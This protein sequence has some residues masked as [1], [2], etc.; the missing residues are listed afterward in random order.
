MFPHRFAHL[1]EEEFDMNNF[2]LPSDRVNFEDDQADPSIPDRLENFARKW[3]HRIAL[4]T[5]KISLPWDNLNRA[6]N[7]IGRAV[8][9]IS[10]SPWQQPIGLL[11]D[12]ED[13]LVATLG[14][15][16]A[17]GICVAL[18][19]AYP[20]ARLAY[21]LNDTESTLILTNHRY[22]P[23]GLE[24]AQGKCSVINIDALDSCLSTEN[25]G[26]R[27]PSASTCSIT[28]T[29]GSTGEPKGIVNTHR[30]MIQSLVY[31]EH[32]KLGPDDHFTDM[33]SGERNPFSA[34]LNG[35]SL[36]PWYIKEDGL[37]SLSDWLI[38]EE[39]TAFRAG[40][41]VF[42]QFVSNLSGKEEFPQ[43]R[44]IILAGEPM[45]KADVELY[46]RHF[47]ASCVLVNL[48]GAHEVG[49]F[50]IFV[51]N[52]NTEIAGDRVPAGYEIAGKKVLLFDEDRHELGADEV[53]EIAVQSRSLSL[54][55]WRKPALSAAKFLAA[56]GNDEGRIYLTGDLGRMLPNGCLE[57]LGRK[58][59]RVKIRGFS[60][61]IA[62]VEKALLKHAGI[63]EATVTARQDASGEAQLV[64]YFVPSGHAASTVTSLRK[65]L[66][67]SL[68]DY[69]I[70]SVF[71]KLGELPTIGTGT[72]KLD[73]HALPEPGNQRPDLDSSFVA[74]ATPVEKILAE[75]WAEALSMTEI[76]VDDNFFDLGGHSLT[77][78][79][80]IARVLQSFQL[81]LPIKAL[82]DFPTI[83][84]MAKF[85]AQL[86]A[87]LTSKTD[88][89]RALSE[90]ETMSENKARELLGRQV[91]WNE[92]PNG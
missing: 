41:R 19:P 66:K 62:E 10:N 33:G 81:E 5:K 11:L 45:C 20:P 7:R 58:D 91:A 86:Q 82:F 36:F 21:V 65:L 44:G 73:R 1:I 80:I 63:K 48:L 43:L 90:I 77:A 71:V 39:I 72:G 64:V 38:G 53:G 2:A 47:A 37:A 17:G 56:P 70:P 52:K 6:A 85:I 67:R 83:A 24:L 69:M 40:P 35:A 55:Y 14:V 59:F 31:G 16:K 28:Y 13:L 4:K 51:I 68:P 76:G 8:L 57:H 30:K 50:R 12:K 75:I 22:F 9:A 84:E 87:K 15:L 46:K 79:G 23:L 32:F 3:P 29:S 92:K 49:P 89:E 78:T 61:D 54:G 60:V 26:M 18:T 27:I 34:L 42:R 88:F 74:P 25:L